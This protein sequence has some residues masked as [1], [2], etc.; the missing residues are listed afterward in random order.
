MDFMKSGFMP[1]CKVIKNRLQYDQS[2]GPNA[3]ACGIWYGFED[4]DEN[5]QS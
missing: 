3:A 4:D 1:H 5:D 2:C